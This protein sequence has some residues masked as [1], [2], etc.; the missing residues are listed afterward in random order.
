MPPLKSSKI[1]KIFLKIAGNINIF[2]NPLTILKLVLSWL[3]NF[4]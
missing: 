1:L 3:K 2:P 4:P